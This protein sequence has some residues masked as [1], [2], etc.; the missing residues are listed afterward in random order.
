[1][2]SISKKEDTR[3][4]AWEV[5]QRHDSRIWF[6]AP[7]SKHYEGRSF[8]NTPHSFA[9]VSIT[10]HACALKCEHCNAGLLRAMLPAETPEKLR[11]AVDCLIER[12]C[13]GILVSGGADRQGVVPL[14]GFAKAIE[15]AC[16]RGLKV[17][18][19]TGLLEK[20][21][22]MKLKDCGVNQVLMDIIGHEKTIREV[23]HLDRKPDDYLR[24]M[25]VCRETGLDFA[26]HVVI[27]L[28]FGR[29]FGEYEALKMIREA[30]PESLVLVI[31][32]PL[33]GSSMKAVSPPLLSELESVL[34]SA[35]LENPDIFLNLG[36][37]R[38]AGEYKRQVEKL[39]IDYGCNGIAFPGD[40]AIDH[41]CSRGL[42]PVFTEECCSMAGN[43]NN[44]LD[45]RQAHS[46]MT[47]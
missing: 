8:R 14:D 1:L 31:L 26:P 23:Y 44:K 9:H 39:A 42:K 34:A 10:G 40:E 33:A 16:K 21:T 43:R 37:A 24:S 18:V 11:D 32:M 29:I 5:R 36:C 46:G 4:R 30:Q 12:G 38:P 27:G 28:H 3:Q 45:P 22:A 6:S 20:E 7:G 41:A 25:L 17:L 19:H 15:Y 2:Y 35:R 47:S 13:R